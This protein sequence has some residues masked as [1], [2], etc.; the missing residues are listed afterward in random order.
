M[1]HFLIIKNKQKNHIQKLNESDINTLNGL[2]PGEDFILKK[3]NDKKFGIT[4]YVWIIKNNFFNPNYYYH[5]D[6][7]SLIIFNGWIN[8]GIDSLINRADKLPIKN[9]IDKSNTTG[10]FF[11]FY[12]DKINKIAYIRRSLNGSI[13]VYHG[14]DDKFDVFSSRSSIAAYALYGNGCKKNNIDIID[15]NYISEIISTSWALSSNSLYKN[16]EI[17]KQGVDISIL[18]NMI[19]YD[20]E[21]NPWYDREFKELYSKN[22]KIYWDKAYESIVSN[23]E[24]I[25]KTFGSNFSFP[26][27]G[28]KDSRV[29]L[30]LIMK[31]SKNKTIE[32]VFTNGPLYSGEYISAK[33]VAKHLNLKHF[34]N[35]SGYYG[36]TVH[37]KILNHIFVTE[38]EVSPMDLS[39]KYLVKNKKIVLRGQESGLRNIANRLF[40]TEEELYNWA[41]RHFGNFNVTGFLNKDY[42]NH[43]ELNFKQYFEETVKNTKIND[44]ATRQRLETRYLRWGARIWSIHNLNEFSPFI[45]LDENVVKSA[46]NIGGENRFNQE[47]HYEILKRCDPNLLTIPFYNQDWPEKYGIKTE[48]I[49]NIINESRPMRGTSAVL[50]NSW[51]KMKSFIIDSLEVNLSDVIDFDKLKNFT[52][53]D[54]KSGH[55]QPLWQLV[56][57]ASFFN[58]NYFNDTSFIP[59]KKLPIMIDEVGNGNMNS[60]N[61]LNINLETKSLALEKYKSAFIKLLDNNFELIESQEKHNLKNDNYIEH[62]LNILEDGS[63]KIYTD[64]EISKNIR[65]GIFG[66]SVTREAFS[67][68]NADSF[69]KQYYGTIS[70]H[71]LVSEPTELEL[72]N[73][74]FSSWQKQMLYS[75]ISKNTF[76]YSTLD[77]LIV[78]LVDER[79]Q[80]LK[81]GNS[82]ITETKELINDKKIISQLMPK[83]LFKRGTIEDFNL[84]ISSCKLFKE[85][86]N[87]YKLKIILNKVYYSDIYLSKNFEKKHFNNLDAIKRMNLLLDTYYS[88]FE[89]IVQPQFI[90]KFNKNTAVAVETH[91]WGLSPYHF[92]DE[93]YKYIFNSIE[94]ILKKIRKSNN[95]EQ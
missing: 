58:Y 80:I 76:N 60:E 15:K 62:N 64:T 17:I 49:Q 83:S 41:I 9:I 90:I 69:V 18:N 39:Y 38:G 55:F 31:A 2:I 57:M 3:F 93:Y 24:I 45:F 68:C 94:D 33:K 1:I 95:H 78:D 40:S 89:E 6:P 5:E 91:K 47:F 32:S 11:L 54:I 20:R 35:E 75:D 73:N 44:F 63:Q 85:K 8:Y 14:K 27:S 67:I 22:K 71:S 53:N 28:G 34:N 7:N 65:I 61:R 36:L 79:L 26:L 4:T 12:Y 72:T 84:W 48:S 59:K 50:N 56:G 77:V 23:L 42:Q 82:Y 29:L 16:V 86:L 52:S 10:E 43:N 88:I 30:A 92:V 21:E 51:D 46:Y 74:N 87:K 37:D 13:Q 66:S 81:V 19:K 25:L 70:L